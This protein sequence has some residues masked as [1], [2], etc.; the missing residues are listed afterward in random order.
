MF[1][2]PWRLNG[3]DIGGDGDE[4]M[5]AGGDSFGERGVD[6]LPIRSIDSWQP[7]LPD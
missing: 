6:A 3:S 1:G 5:T 4:L 2:E 7:M